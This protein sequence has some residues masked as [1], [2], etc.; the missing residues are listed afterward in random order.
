M[1][2][3]KL[4]ILYCLNCIICFAQ[5]GILV[6]PYN[7]YSTQPSPTYLN[8]LGQNLETVHNIGSEDGFTGEYEI[9]LDNHQWVQ[10]IGNHV[11]TY[12]FEVVGF[13]FTMNCAFDVNNSCANCLP[14]RK[15]NLPE[16]AYDYTNHTW[17][18][19]LYNDMEEFGA[20]EFNDG[21][22]SVLANNWHQTLVS[23][24]FNKSSFNVINLNRIYFPHTT[25]KL[26]LFL[27]CNNDYVNPG[28]VISEVSYLYDN[29]RG[30]MRYYPFKQD[31]CP[32]STESNYDVIF[33]PSVVN[34]TYPIVMYYDDSY[35]DNSNWTDGLG[36]LNYHSVS[37][38]ILNG[39]TTITAPS[40]I[41]QYWDFNGPTLPFFNMPF[42]GPYS[43]QTCHLFDSE[44]QTLAGYNNEPNPTIN[45]SLNQGILHEYRIENE[46]DLSPINSD[47]M[48]IYNPSEVILEPKFPLPYFNLNFPSNY[49]F[50]TIRGTFPNINQVNDDNTTENGG[51]FLD[52]DVPVRTDLRSENLNFPHDVNNNRHSVYASKYLL[53][54]GSQ[55]TIEP[56]VGLFDLYFEVEAGATLYFVDFS[57]IRGKEDKSNYTTGRY[58]I[59]GDGGAILRNYENIQYVQNAILTQTQSLHYLAWNS[60]EAGNNVDPD[61]DQPQGDYSIM[62]GANVTFETE[63][64]IH[65]TNGF[66]VQGGDFHAKVSTTIPSANSC[67]Q[68]RFNHPNSQ[69]NLT[70]PK[71]SFSY[72]A[73]CSPN[74]NNG[75]WKLEAS[76]MKSYVISNVMGQEIYR[77]E[78]IFSNEEQI[79]LNSENPGLYF[80]KITSYEGQTAVVKVIIE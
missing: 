10:F 22:N 74:P 52:I 28:P 5:Q 12:K 76:N 14:D 56:C 40:A 4:I 31:N 49:T 66:S 54:S 2:C 46:F 65:L 34:S 16:S 21:N 11:V 20:G 61:T 27:H 35:Q 72:S 9:N 24:F 32:G 73:H 37:N 45:L 67:T 69:N 47:D 63:K 62:A 78:Q 30:R 8:I 7:D 68:A 18:Q 33:R 44:G 64:F 75:T 50:K 41:N 38:I 17:N 70:K 80:I 1:K 71:K 48:V 25:L 58:K 42:L 51:P 3:I 53:N 23:D 26:N 13:P 6:N 19:Y 15:L 43:L 36:T 60:I 39:C 79:S 59:K 77:K 55:I 57:T 29:T